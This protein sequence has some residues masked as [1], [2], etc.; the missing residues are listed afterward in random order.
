M[1]KKYLYYCGLLLFILLNPI[2]CFGFLEINNPNV[3]IIIADDLGWSDVGYNGSEIN[4]P[5]INSLADTGIIL[6][7]FYVS[8]ACSPTRTSLMTGRSHIRTNVMGPIRKGQPKPP[9]S[10]YFLSQAFKDNGYQTALI[11]KWHLGGETDARYRPNNR[12]FSSF[13]G[14]IG[15]GIDHFK[16]THWRLGHHDWYRNNTP[17]LE[18]NYST[19]LITNESIKIIS[20]RTP[21]KP[22]F[23]ITSYAA[24]HKPIQAHEKDI[25]K[26]MNISN[27]KRRSYAAMVDSM[28]KGIGKILQALDKADMTS[29]TIVFFMSDNGG[30]YDGSS[31]EPLKGGK[32]TFYEGGTRVPAFISW[33][34]TIPNKT[35]MNQ[36]IN[37][38][39]IYPTLLE[40]AGV[41][42]Y[43]TNKID[44]KSKWSQL[45][46]NKHSINEPTIHDSFVLSNANGTGAIW[47]DNWK[48]IIVPSKN[49][50]MLYNFVDDPLEANDLSKNHTKKVNDLTEEYY[51]KIK[52]YKINQ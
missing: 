30:H 13:Y 23:M 44:G 16:H 2:Y 32:F 20:T 24:P 39:D 17:L 35:I 45:T 41:K 48:L 4:T 6:N 7:R 14:F 15:G 40:G 38:M 19:D 49:K 3:L 21:D 11:G 5:N 42:D 36:F 33:P 28:D 29:N 22:L 31:N 46:K 18:N 47:K 43:K 25:K 10:E 52:K 9:L 1:T 37:V 8:P 12:G 27:T 50:K 26:Y 34:G 51:K